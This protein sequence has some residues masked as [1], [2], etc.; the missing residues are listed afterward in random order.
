MTIGN[1]VQF[2]GIV[3]YR[4]QMPVCCIKSKTLITRV[5][6]NISPIGNIV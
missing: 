1:W 4:I 2:M 3:L 6:S 5:S